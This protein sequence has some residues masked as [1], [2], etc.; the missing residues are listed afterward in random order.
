MEAA[1]RWCPDIERIVLLDFIHRLV[2]QKKLRNKNI[3]TKKSQ[4]TRLWLVIDPCVNFGRVYCD[5][6]VY[7]FLF[8][9]FF[10]TPED[11]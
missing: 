2:S 1:K 4:Y 3:Y 5:F 9:N 7:I 11:G 10:E 6:L 8:L